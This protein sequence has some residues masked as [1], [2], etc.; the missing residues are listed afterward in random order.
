[1][2]GL[3]RIMFIPCFIPPHKAISQT[4]PPEDRLNMTRLACEGNPLFEVS[5]MEIAAKELSYTVNTLEAFTKHENCET[6]FVLGT[7]SLRD[8]HTWKDYERLFSL[9]HFIAVTRPDT[10]FRSAWA[11]VPRKLRGE[12]HWEDGHL[13]HSSSRALIP[14]PV[15]GLEISATAVRNLVKSGNSIRYLVPESVRSYIHE[16][17]LYRN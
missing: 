5:D 17:H 13:S 3:D 15:K 14:S 2:H 11:H 9:S 1:V 4:A 16:K 8:I 10:D 7:D 6:F 12:F